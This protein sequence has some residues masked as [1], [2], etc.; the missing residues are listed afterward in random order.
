M[1]AIWAWF[2]TWGIAALVTIFIFNPHFI[3]FVCV[4]T[5]D[6]SSNLILFFLVFKS[7]LS[8]SSL[9]LLI[10]YFTCPF[11]TLNFEGQTFFTPCPLLLA[12][13]HY[14]QS[15]VDVNFQFPSTFIS[16]SLKFIFLRQLIGYLRIEFWLKV[17]SPFHHLFLDALYLFHIH[18]TI[19]Y[20]KH[21]IVDIFIQSSYKDLLILLVRPEVLRYFDQDLL[22]KRLSLSSVLT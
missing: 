19:V 18:G 9:P 21:P 10:R 11:F 22:L 14:F 12:C 7:Y 4:V 17:S 13:I 16:S 15:L 20:S 2:G 3:L 1:P 5:P 6:L 8:C